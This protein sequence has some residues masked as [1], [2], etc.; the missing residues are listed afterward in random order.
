MRGRGHA[1]ALRRPDNVHEWCPSVPLSEV[2]FFIRT[3]YLA[4]FT[5]QS[6]EVHHELHIGRDWPTAVSLTPPLSTT[7][8]PSVLR[9]QQAGY[10]TSLRPCRRAAA[11]GKT[12]RVRWHIRSCMDRTLRY[13]TED[14]YVELG[15]RAYVR[16]STPDHTH[17][18][19]QHR[20]PGKLLLPLLCCCPAAAAGKTSMNDDL[21][22]S[23]AV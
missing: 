1:P 2:C 17:H 19:Y 14:G 10:Y 21:K 15:V 6:Y 22:V 20:P 3:R 23:T 5:N 7:I 13:L 18:D 9:V 8:V 16:I 12:K 11:A 4:S